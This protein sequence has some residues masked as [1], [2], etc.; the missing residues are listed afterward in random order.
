MRAMI[1][2]ACG[3]TYEPYVFKDFTPY[4]VQLNVNGMS[5]LEIERNG[6]MHGKGKIE[7]CPDCMGKVTNFVFNSLI[8]NEDAP[9][10][11]KIKRFNNT[12]PSNEE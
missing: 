9:Y 1:C 3:R 5:L 2:D 4:K 8:V 10:I 11:Q 6:K 12:E 7:L